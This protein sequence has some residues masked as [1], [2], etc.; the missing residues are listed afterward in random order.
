MAW[1][2]TQITVLGRFIFTTLI[3][4]RSRHYAGAD[5]LKRWVNDDSEGN[6]VV[7]EALTTPFYTL[8]RAVHLDGGGFNRANRVRIVRVMFSTP[9]YWTQETNAMTTKPPIDN[10]PVL[11]TIST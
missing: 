6:V 2:H 9:I 8:L 11:S 5:Y 4:R 7:S 1:D 3:A 10:L